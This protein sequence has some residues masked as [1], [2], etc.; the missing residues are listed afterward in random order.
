MNLQNKTNRIIES[1]D[2]NGWVLVR[3]ENYPISIFLEF[4]KEGSRMDMQFMEF[5]QYNAVTCEISIGGELYGNVIT[6]DNFE[7]GIKKISENIRKEGMPDF[8]E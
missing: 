6:D 8:D 3:R 7:E 4:E 1:I 5:K 2:F